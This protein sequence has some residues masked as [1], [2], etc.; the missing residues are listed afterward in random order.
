[1]T[2]LAFSSVRSCVN[3]NMIFFASKRYPT[4]QASFSSSYQRAH[5]FAKN[6][7]MPYSSACR[8]QRFSSQLFQHFKWELDAHS[9]RSRELSAVSVFY[10]GGNFFRKPWFLI[11]VA[12]VTSVLTQ[13]STVKADR[14][15]KR[16]AICGKF[17]EFNSHNERI[18]RNVTLHDGNPS[19][20]NVGSFVFKQ[21]GFWG[22]WKQYS[23]K[24]DG[25][26]NPF[27]RNDF[28]LCMRDKKCYLVKEASHSCGYD[29]KFSPV[30]G[31]DHWFYG[32]P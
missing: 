22:R 16:F 12:L 6:H 13:R 26:P 25:Q 21:K 19:C 7:L 29:Q 17:R 27:F 18:C 10:E 31:E 28:F 9:V 1:M 23:G 32:I 15:I 20:H 24:N 11:C 14:C 3:N 8:S 30:G 4:S 5:L 2:I